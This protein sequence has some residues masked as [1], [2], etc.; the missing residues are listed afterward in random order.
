[1]TPEPDHAKT[2]FL[3][4]IESQAPENWE[5]WLDEACG[6]DAALRS[7]VA[8]LLKAHQEMGT[9]RDDAPA[10]AR[11]IDLPADP[12][13]TE[14]LG[15]VIGPYK[16]LQKIGEGGM[17]VV[18]MADQLAPVRRKV[19]LKIIKPG[20]DTREVIA[21]FEAERQ[22]LALMDHPHIAR[23]FD[24]GATAAG[25][26]YFVMELVRGVPLTDYC[27]QNN[28]PVHERLEL[29]ITVCHAVQHAH[30]KG[31][32]HRDIKPSNVLVTLHDGRAV[33]KVIDFGVA[34]AIGQQLTDKT[35]FTQF[36][37]MVG[38]P[39]YMSPE[40][41]ELSALGVDT[42]GDIYSLGVM[43]YE[44]LTGTTPFDSA[45]MKIVALEEIRRIIREE[46]PP[47]P[48]T[49]LSSTA[50]ETQTSVAAHRHIDPRGLSRLVRGDLD[51]IVMKALEKDRNRRYETANGLAM[52]V[53]RYLNDEPVLACPPS[54]WYR[55]R[56]LARRNKRAFGA[57]STAALLVL[58]TA[59]SLAV[60]NVRIRQEQARTKKEMVRAENAQKLAENRAEEIRQGVE[61]LKAADGLLERGRWYVGEMRWDDAHSAFT[62]AIELYPEHATMWGERGDLYAGLG[63]WDLAAADF[64]REM[65]LREPDAA[66]RWFQYA[67]LRLSIGDSDGYGKVCRRMRER[68]A[69][70]LDALS[71]SDMVR[72]YVLSPGA[73]ADLAW[74]VE[75]AQK[76]LASAPD[77]HWLLFAAGVAHYRAGQYEQAVQQLRES[78]KLGPHWTGRSRTYPI[79]AMAHRRL[80]QESEARQA[81]DAASEAID[82]CTRERF[83]GGERRHWVFHQ[84][85]T[86]HWPTDW[87]DYLEAQHYYR[88]AN[89]LIK[90]SSPPDDPRLHVLRAL[91]FAGLRRN[92]SAD[93]EYAAALKLRPDDQQVRLE[94]HR[95]AGYTAVGRRQWDRAATEFTKASEM[96]PDDAYLWR[97]RA[98]AYLA[99][100]DLDDYRQT[101]LAALE[102]FE[103]TTDHSVAGNVVLVCVLRDDA[104]PDVARL[105][106]LARVAA[107]W[108]SCGDYLLGGALYRAGRH[109]EAVKCF[110]EAA[111]S[112]RPGAS[113]WSFLAMAHH[114]LG[115]ADE[116][117]RCLAEAARWI[118][119]ANRHE[120]DD[121]SATR[122]AWGG[123][124]EPVV[125]P[126]LLREAESLVQREEH[127][128]QPD[129]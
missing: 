39:L 108:F 69:R 54:F 77:A 12:R 90:G 113:E 70:T 8:A 87:W 38:T 81:L 73:E 29:F 128:T 74:T 30:Q 4:A 63:L 16:L 40:Q 23:V 83:L 45:R 99:A 51:W 47:S 104:L 112:F 11:T 123:W 52:D 89:L 124:H 36:A 61:R 71:A 80:G 76:C 26:P 33:P 48:S 82:R 46:D 10:V 110:E 103:S 93:V 120:G 18:Y 20:M 64:A 88:A 96:A 2:I 24:A 14:T 7:R 6:N 21:R 107:R 41:A 97:F 100:G 114:R 1:M 65:E 59:I 121:L 105:L 122:P 37:Q 102:R 115:H 78:L 66:S 28:L 111:K 109:D 94:A 49:R 50:G 67:L 43:L 119:E 116:A 17:G 75:L 27:D 34:K 31:I 25:R 62:K 72:T 35:L 32:I 126:L 92:S 85:V 127:P 68:F 79:L 56:K 13:V 106:P 60:S 3:R 55:F 5:A 9:F 95:S 22:A 91:A 98:V 57:A 118:D 101:C 42:R 53:Q 86:G 129:Y 44:L 58:L 19:A 84:G 15:T 125:F 117:R